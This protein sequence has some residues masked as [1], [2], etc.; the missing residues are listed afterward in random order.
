MCPYRMVD[1]STQVSTRMGMECFVISVAVSLPPGPWN[2][3][4][5]G[6]PPEVVLAGDGSPNPPPG[7]NGDPAWEHRTCQGVQL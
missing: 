7:P 6:R 4:D 1:R 2:P 5:M 3:E